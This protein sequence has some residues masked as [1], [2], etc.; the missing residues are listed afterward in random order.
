MFYLGFKVYLKVFFIRKDFIGVKL[1]SN[2]FIENES[3]A[4]LF[5]GWKMGFIEVN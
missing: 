2:L 1:G 5:E 3:L 4:G